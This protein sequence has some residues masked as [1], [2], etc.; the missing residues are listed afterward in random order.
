MTETPATTPIAEPSSSAADTR[1]KLKALAE[2][3]KRKEETELPGA[4]SRQPRAQ[5]LD[6]STI[7]LQQPDFRFH[8]VNS[9]DPS[10]VK[11][12]RRMGYEPVTDKEAEEAGVDARLSDGSVLMKVPRPKFDQRVAQF[13]Q[14]H[15]ARLKA[16]KTDVTK[17]A[18]SLVRELKDKYGVNV[19]LERL[20]I[21]E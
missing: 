16:H 12:R 4:A 13:K 7:E 19:P 21:S 17:I 5:L 3:L 1:A 11:L 14:M 18:E 15:E 9:T 8:Y 10:K 20:L 2:S 6:A